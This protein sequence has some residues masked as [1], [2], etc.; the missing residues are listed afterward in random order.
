MA[1]IEL[2]LKRMLMQLLS[3]RTHVA[4]SAVAAHDD[5]ELLPTRI[6]FMQ[7]LRNCTPVAEAAVEAHVVAEVA[8][9]ALH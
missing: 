5:A 3:N 7:L 4:E 1:F 9:E 8:A 6:S 2:L